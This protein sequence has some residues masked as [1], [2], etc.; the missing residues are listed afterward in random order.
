[1]TTFAALVI[2]T[3][4]TGV[5]VDMS[6][7][8]ATWASDAVFAA[9]AAVLLVAVPATRKRWWRVLVAYGVM[10][11]A[12]P[13]LAAMVAVVVQGYLA[14]WG[15]TARREQRAASGARQRRS[16]Q[17]DKRRRRPAGRQR[18]PYREEK[19]RNRVKS[20]ISPPS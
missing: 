15:L 13:T 17:A 3:L 2:G 9:L 12:E 8:M 1:M 18:P 19:C 5:E 20:A 11:V 10:A 14:W 16:G 7:Q 4:S 6:R